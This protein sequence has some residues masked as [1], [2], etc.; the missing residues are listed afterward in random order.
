MDGM[1]REG[2]ADRRGILVLSLSPSQIHGTSVIREE[3]WSSA[4]HSGI[5]ALI[6][7]DVF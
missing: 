4:T 7:L 2:T 1:R 3:D 6:F 5:V